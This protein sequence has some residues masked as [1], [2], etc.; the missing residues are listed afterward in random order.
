MGTWSQWPIS[1][2]TD[3]QAASLRADRG[4]VMCAVG[5][6]SY[7]LSHSAALISSVHDFGAALPLEL[8]YGSAEATFIEAH[9]VTWA[10]QLKRWGVAAVARR[11]SA[12]FGLSRYDCKVEALLESRFAEALFLDLD[13]ALLASPLRLFASREYRET[14][15]LFF[16]D[17]QKFY[18]LKT[19]ASSRWLRGLDYTLGVRPPYAGLHSA[20]GASAERTGAERGAPTEGL[21]QSNIFRGCSAHRA[22]S[23]VIAIDLKRHV[24]MLAVLRDR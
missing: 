1:T 20:S 19:A 11:V 6:K 7:A 21:R 16:R 12:P 17:R 22:E 2:Y 10:A 14:G 23:S 18:K 15:A 8:F 4:V 13:V 9:A 3:V 5:K 24:R